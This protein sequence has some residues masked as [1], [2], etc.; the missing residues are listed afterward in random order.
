MR[1]KHK[2]LIVRARLEKPPV[3]LDTVEAWVKELGEGEITSGVTAEGIFSVLVGET[4]M[5]AARFWNPDV[6][7]LDVCA[8]EV[9]PTDVFDHIEEFIILSKSHLFLDRTNTIQQQQ[10]Y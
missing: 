5:I 8:S 1:M 9:S 7:Q 2:H 6:L 10:V 3:E 4:N